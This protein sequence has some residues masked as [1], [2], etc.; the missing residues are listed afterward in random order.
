MKR[1]D[2][3]KN[4]YDLKCIEILSYK[5]ILANIMK[6]CIP[7]YYDSDIDTIMNKYI[8]SNYQ[9]NNEKIFGLKKDFKYLTY[10]IFFNSKCPNS[11]DSI[12]LLINLEPQ[13]TTKSI[14][15][16]IFNRALFYTAN[17]IMYQYNTIFKNSRYDL[18]KKVYS[19]FI[20]FDA[21]TKE[22]ENSIT[23]FNL[24]K[25]IKLGYNKYEEYDKVCIIVIYLGISNSNHE[26]LRFIELLFTSELNANKILDS[27]HNE[28][29][30]KIS[31]P[32]LQEVDEMCNLSERI[33]ERGIRKG[34]EQGIEQGIVL[35]AYDSILN[36]MNSFNISFDQAV[37]AL[38]LSDK[39][40]E[41]CKTKYECNKNG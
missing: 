4:A 15:Y 25:D 5:M 3:Y 34:I 6:R 1:K 41:I 26:L 18:L 19:I 38:K 22:E 20:C 31:K 24:T 37:V 14:G 16:N 35:Q 33:E 32:F 40:I 28:Y 39:M 10:D 23:Y 7:E 27:L 29:G 11:N 21:P 8:E 30:I 9:S 12:G 2:K 17:A 36:I 13:R